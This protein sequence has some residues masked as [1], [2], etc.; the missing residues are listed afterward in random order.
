MTT[1][2]TADTEGA[3]T[4]YQGMLG[5]ASRIASGA[6]GS[7]AVVGDDLRA[8]ATVHGFSRDPATM[9]AIG[10]V[11]DAFAAAAAAAE[12]LRSG[13]VARHEAGEEYHAGQ[14][15]DASAFRPA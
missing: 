15:A 13:M 8:A 12:A 2:P 7:A 4:P 1:P 6:R 10:Q 9:T 11:E 5:A 3:E 14:D